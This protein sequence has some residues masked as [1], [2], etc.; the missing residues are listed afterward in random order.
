M[1]LLKGQ[2][3]NDTEREKAA[4]I[5]EEKLKIYQEYLH[6]LSDVIKDHS[7]S[8]EA[9]MRLEFQTSYVAMHCNPQYIVPVSNAVRKI[10]EYSCPDQEKAIEAKSQSGSPDP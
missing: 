10:I 7:L 5:F 1:I 8:D 9:K 4:K 6:T 2:T 3:E